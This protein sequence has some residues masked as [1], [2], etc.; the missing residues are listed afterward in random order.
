MHLSIGKARAVADRYKQGV[1]VG[2]DT[3]VVY[4]NQILGKPHT[5]ES[6]RSR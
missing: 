6:D 2:A 1:I 3:F 4:Q 5:P